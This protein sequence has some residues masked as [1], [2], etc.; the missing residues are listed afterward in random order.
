M[1]LHIEMIQWTPESEDPNEVVVTTDEH[2]E[3]IA[4]SDTRFAVSLFPSETTLTA[5]ATIVLDAI[6]L[7]SLMQACVLHGVKVVKV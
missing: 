3:W 7:N 4:D 2:G 1:A 6:G 5:Q